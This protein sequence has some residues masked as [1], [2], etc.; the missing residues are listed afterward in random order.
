[1]SKDTITTR[2]SNIRDRED[3]IATFNLVV[4]FETCWTCR[5]FKRWTHGRMTC[6]VKRWTHGRITCRVKRWT[7]G[8]TS[9]IR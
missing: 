6:R 8:R 7:H 2:F 5:R 4:D 1:M 9:R 3:K